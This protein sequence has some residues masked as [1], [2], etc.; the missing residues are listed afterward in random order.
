[1]NNY[2][3]Q[4]VTHEPRDSSLVKFVR[5]GENIAARVR[6][7]VA[8]RRVL[9]IGFLVLASLLFIPPWFLIPSL[10]F[11]GFSLLGFNP[12]RFGS[13][14]RSH[15]FSGAKEGSSPTQSVPS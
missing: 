11:A 6:Q 3:D 14:G 1:M 7:D 13:R 15:R 12:F 2:S 8:I 10:V 9:G 4:N 5:E